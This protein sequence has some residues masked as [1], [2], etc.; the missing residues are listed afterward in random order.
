[1][2]ILLL[3][4]ASVATSAPALAQGLHAGPSW[5]VVA[6]FERF[7]ARGSRDGLSAGRLL[8]G[9][10]NCISCHTGS[11]AQE[12]PV[13]RKSAPVLDGV[14]GRIKPGYLRRFLNNPQA[15]KP[16]TTMPDVLAGV[17]A[18]DRPAT[19]EALV[20]FLASTGSLKQEKPQKKLIGPGRDLYHKV[21]CVVCHGT[22]D[23]AG[24]QDRLFATSVPLG[25]LTSKYTLASLRTFLE[26]PHAARPSG[27]MPAL[28]SGKEAAQIANYLLQGAA[29]DVTAALNMT[30]AYYEGTWQNLPDFDKLKPLATGMAAGFDLGLARRANDMAMK[31][32][33]FLK[34]ERDGEYRFH[35]TS[36][37]GSKLYVA[38]KLVVAN[39]GIHP[40]TTQS[41]TTT[42]TRGAHRFVATV[43][44]AGGGVELDIDIEGPGLG[45]QPASPFIYLTPDG[46]PAAKKPAS[47][48]DAAPLA[49]QASL[50]DKGRTVF[51][52]VGCAN[53]HSLSIGQ[54]L[55]SSLRAPPL[56]RLA[57][58]GGCLDANPRP[59]VPHY[60]LSGAQRSALIAA[61][62]APAP[63]GKPRPADMIA[64]TM[65]A[66]NCYACH[67]RA[68]VGGALP[69][70]NPY[71]V[72]AQPEMGDEGR[73][74]PS[75]TGVGAK[76]NAE[77]LR[78][79]LDKGAHD[80]PYM[81]TRMPGFGNENVGS[82]V[83]LFA[84][85]DPAPSV[86]RVTFDISL[87]KVKAEARGLI[88]AGALGCIKCHTFAGYKA[89]GVQGIDMTTMTR[90]LRKE[91]FH[92]YM[93]DPNKYRPG[94]R[95]PA[96]WPGGQTL[97][98][99]YLGGTADK[100]IEGIWIFL[101]DEARAPLPPGLKK[102]AI[103]L[104][105]TKDAIVYRNF[106][107]G[108]GPRAIAVGYPEQAHLAFDANNLRLAMIWQ[109]A[110]ID[111][112]R[113]WTDRGAGFEPPAGDNIVHF[114]ST[115]AF[116]ILNRPDQPW[117]KQ[118]AREMS[119]YQ[120]NGYRLTSD[121][122]P[123]FL[124]T[125]RGVKIEDF[126]NA[127]AGT[128]CA[129]IRR[130]ITLSADAPVEKLFFRAAVAGKIAS[131]GDGWYQV[132]ELKMHIESDAP[133]QIRAN[134][135][136]AELLVP[137]RFRDGRA[138]IVQEFQW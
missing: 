65:I 9:E 133:P 114:P 129:S 87:P 32:E 95:M 7:H 75:L 57:A 45:R 74:P 102:S 108:A 19:V 130:T 83:A 69:E 42:L 84:D 110:F 27:R 121:E 128:T 2:R 3:V 16:G 68:Q 36:D 88:G 94:T 127:V 22:R 47:D 122:R 21:G 20:H 70:L 115:V 35:V 81:F 82:L 96:A 136:Q 92:H 104:V 43:F 60:P 91:W 99:K 86:P 77:Y 14:G 11:P 23:A 29:S 54:K 118:S 119:G 111:A 67:E 131:L 18:K 107:E 71:F 62:E 28:V 78:Q 138:K 40:P 46:N 109:G 105:P 101:T 93:L 117:P 49:V 51:T 123:T 113:H 6:G 41:G 79:V 38:G 33:G 100:Q 116:A 4:L 56:A 126:P 80:R 15:A 135:G 34:V 134:E 10:L 90:R 132:N 5:P 55:A 124:Y 103:L 25:D 1:M 120:F 50:A 89:E 31:F 112:S 53:C 30:Y 76:L 13:V 63:A 137:V 85:A 98:P 12:A 8:L 26:N 37:D 61:V 24:N 73:L 64:R 44:N 52:S 39:D 106:I 72:T 17:P 58:R 59:A 66:F 48:R 97:L 125:I